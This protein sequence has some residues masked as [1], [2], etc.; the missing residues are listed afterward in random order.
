MTSLHSCNESTCLLL[1]LNEKVLFLSVEHQG[2]PDI[3]NFGDVAKYT[4]S[5]LTGRIVTDCVWLGHND[6]PCY[7]LGYCT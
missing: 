6:A 1:S 4:Y 5:E 2:I 3:S 7:D